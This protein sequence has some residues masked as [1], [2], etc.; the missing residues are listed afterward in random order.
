MTGHYARTDGAR[1]MRARAEDKDQSYVLYMLGREQLSR[2]RFPMGEMPSKAYAR[3]LAR[4]LGLHLA[5][6]PDSQ[7]ICFVSE[8]GGYADFLRKRRPELFAPGEIVDE[9]GRVL[10]EHDGVAAFT[11]GQRRGV[12]VSGVKPLYVLSL[13]P[14]AN[15]VTVGPS[16]ALLTREVRL[17]SFSGG[18]RPGEARRV[19]AKIRSNMAAL[20]GVLQM[21]EAPAIVFDAPVRAA[22]PGRSRWPTRATSS[23]AAA[24]SRVRSG[25]EGRETFSSP[26]RSVNVKIGAGV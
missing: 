25:S 8:A 16:D 3:G 15:R 7:E 13:Q 6:K 10:G 11:V 5:D 12:G 21:G 14:G 9:E 17:E 26:T 20:P 1:L 18:L 19:E 4:E 2:T 23:W 24:S 22:A